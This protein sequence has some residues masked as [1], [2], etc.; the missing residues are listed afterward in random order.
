MIPREKMYFDN[1]FD[2]EEAIEEIRQEIKQAQGEEWKKDLSL[3]LG[4]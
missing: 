4:I 2:I 3:G 1:H